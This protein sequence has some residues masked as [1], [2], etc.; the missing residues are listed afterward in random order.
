MA[1]P[2]QQ[3]L[4][5]VRGSPILFIAAHTWG[6]TLSPLRIGQRVRA[7]YDSQTFGSDPRA[8]EVGRIAQKLA[9]TAMP[10]S[11]SGSASYRVLWEAGGES[12]RARSSIEPLRIGDPITIV[13]PQTP[14][15][16]GTSRSGLL[17]AVLSRKAGSRAGV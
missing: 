4:P 10:G 12:W 7:T 9:A 16:P 1:I 6:V 5:P 17:F 14:R 13:V 15:A 11:D 3:P 8:G 2:S